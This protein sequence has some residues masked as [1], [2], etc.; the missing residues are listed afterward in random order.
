[1]HT[2][3]RFI[4]TWM[5]FLLVLTLILGIAGCDIA[6]ITSRVQPLPTVTPL[7]T[8]QLPDWI[9]QISPTGAA[10]PLAQIRIRFKEPLIPVENLDSPQQQ[11]LLNKF[12]ILPPLKG[13]FRFLTPRMV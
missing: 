2:I 11:N 5:P 8:P 6:K 9:E 12:E 7:P 3:G 1:M 13:Q 4:R 10:E